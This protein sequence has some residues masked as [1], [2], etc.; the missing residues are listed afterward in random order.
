MHKKP[1]RLL[2]LQAYGE[3]EDYFR[4]MGTPAQADQDLFRSR[5]AAF[6]SR[7][8]SITALASALRVN[9]VL[10]TLNL[11][12]KVGNGCLG[13]KGAKALA[14]ALC[15]NGVLTN[16]NISENIIG[17]EGAKAIGKALAI[18]AVLKT[19]IINYN[20][21]GDEGERVIRDAVSG[22]VGFELEM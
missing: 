22:R 12:G 8:K 16:L 10:T 5:R 3:T 1:L 17:V 2:L 9:E 20:N 11:R 7:L 15:V 13:D 4:F 6:Y 14:S 19:L 18:N 21:L